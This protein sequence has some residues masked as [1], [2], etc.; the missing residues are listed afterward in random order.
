MATKKIII[1]LGMHRSGTSALT[2]ALSTMGVRLGDTL[3]P[4]GVDNPTGFWEDRDV[5]A[6]NNKL[7]SR[8]GS[9][10]DRVGV[11]DVDLDGDAVI[12][13]IYQEAKALI[14]DKTAGIPMWGMKDPRIPRL[15][16]FWQKL[17]KEL[18][19]NI[20]Y[21]IALRN[22]LNVANSLAYRNQF[23]SLK[24]YLLWLE[25]ML[26]A[27]A[28]TTSK[29]RLIVGYDNLLGNPR[30]EI[31]R[32]SSALDLPAPIEDDIS[33]YIN[34][35]LDPGLRHAQRSESELLNS[36]IEPKLLADTYVLLNE[37]ALDKIAINSETF[38]D[39]LKPMLSE[40]RSMLPILELIA[41]SERTTEVES[42]KVLELNVALHS[43]N[44]HLQAALKSL[45]NT[46]LENISLKAQFNALTAETEAVHNVTTAETHKLIAQ[47][48]GLEALS[49]TLKFEAEKA[50]LNLQLLLAEKDEAIA[51]L[52]SNLLSTQ[53]IKNDE[54][55]KCDSVIAQLTVENTRLKSELAELNSLHKKLEINLDAWK[56]SEI[57]SAIHIEKLEASLAESNLAAEAD[58]QKYRLLEE[59]VQRDGELKQAHIQTLSNSWTH[60]FNSRTWRLI[61]LLGMKSSLPLIAL[62][63]GEAFDERFYLE[64]YPDVKTAG[65]PAA[66]HYLCFG[67]QEGRSGSAKSKAPVQ[68]APAEEKQVIAVE[69]IVQS[70]HLLHEKTEPF[71]AD[72]YSSMYPDIA[73][74]SVDP[75]RHFL[76]HGKAEGRL[77]VAPSIALSRPIESLP[78][79][80]EEKQVIAVELVVQSDHLLNEKTEPFDADFYSSIYPDIAKSGV[81]PERHFLDHGKAEGRL[82]IAPSIALSRPIESLPAEKPTILLISHEASRTGAPILSLNIV[83]HLTSQF[84]VVALLFGGGPLEESFIEAGAIVAGPVDLR[85][86]PT[87]AEW[88]M[89]ELLDT[90]SFQFAIVNSLE[91]YV[92]LK[93]LA[94]RY[95]PTISLIHEFAVYTRP[96]TAIQN[97]LLWA[98]QT[99]FSADVTLENATLVLPELT[100]CRLP[101]LSQG[102]SIVPGEAHDLEHLE[103]EKAMLQRVMRPDASDDDTI[104]I[105]GAGWVQIRKGVD[106]F[107]ECAT[108]VL[109][110]PIGHKCRFVWIGDNYN[111]EQDTHYSVYLHDQI[112]RAGIAERFTIISET[113]AIEHVYAL[114]DM[115]LLTSRL[116]PLPN[117][118]IDAMVRGLPVLC[119]DKTT[120]IADI[121]KRNG[122]LEACVAPYLD[123]HSMADKLI[124][125]ASSQEARD[126]VG[127]QARSLAAREFNMSRYVGRLLSLTDGNATLSRQELVDTATIQQAE[128]IDFGYYPPAAMQFSGA[129]EAIRR[130]VR[131]WAR[132]ILR[133]KLFP[134]FDPSVYQDINGSTIGAQDPLAH[135]LNAGQPDGPWKWQNLSWERDSTASINKRTLM[136]ISLRSADFMVQILDLLDS[137]SADTNVVILVPDELVALAM[138]QRLQDE[139]NSQ[140]RILVSEDRPLLAILT[141]LTSAPYQDYAAIAHINLNTDPIDIDFSDRD[142][143]QQYL[144]ENMIGG[145]YDALGIIVD[146]LN[147]VAPD[148]D[149]G[150]I[151]PEDP[152]IHEVGADAAII[153]A[154]CESLGFD[155]PVSNLLPFPVNGSFWSAPAI[156]SG[157]LAGTGS[158]KSTFKSLKLTAVEQER[159]IARLLAQACRS[160]GKN[161]ATTVVSGI[162]Y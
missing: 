140:L 151:F 67:I 43:S 62:N 152:N 88:T 99:V 51:A 134:G 118:A 109:N 154:L 129:T 83:Q 144:I 18:E 126:H 39:R 131:S 124:R 20:S 120:G 63:N 49:N 34:E 68:Y 162:T 66:E 4:A 86:Q 146:S 160:H 92:A 15:L 64:T 106:L 157:L 97:A 53:A 122:L 156:L 100:E 57:L 159:I 47:N 69:L 130:Y 59:Q 60:F 23:A 121:L 48:R 104:V 107:I 94:D 128:V 22:P 117:V 108:R 80:A 158:W 55:L 28:Y 21:V 70:D 96:R 133:R 38:E 141:H 148:T 111:P 155:A 142:T 16:P 93:P 54:L 26:Q 149:L 8:L 112:H 3:H 7:L 81:D 153:S 74:S 19:F 52:S 102:K 90:Y 61:S 119:F 11:L 76:D 25:H 82:G 56:A 14:A 41:S 17:L 123:T 77:G 110:S 31:L 73:K 75:E 98:S 161:I 44:E 135:F 79:P 132:G 6:V 50:A 24:S 105:L 9:A 40:L 125:L 30:Q 150:L 138:K 27:V 33:T 139:R 36:Q 136:F 95:I 32:I 114:S 45:T 71:D 10:Y 143:Y 89:G 46:N 137:K 65:I 35:F 58:L 87:I 84:N 1:V 85:H 29:N 42:Q 145:K 5:I 12:E 72:F 127:E 115:L 78:A 116:D 37:C 2:R 147:N 103:A 91:S 13:E 101:V 113:A